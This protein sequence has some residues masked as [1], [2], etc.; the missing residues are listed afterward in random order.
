MV[1]RWLENRLGGDAF[2]AT[3]NYYW[4]WFTLDKVAFVMAE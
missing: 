1:K 2:R 3:R 4:G